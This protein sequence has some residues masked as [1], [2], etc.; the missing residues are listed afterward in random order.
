M[1][2]YLIQLSYAP[3]VLAAGIKKPT[4]RT[5][6]IAKLVESVG[7][8]LVGSWLAFGEYDAVIV[9]DGGDNVSAAALAIVVTASGAFKAF[10]TTPLLTVAEGMEAM[11][12][13]GTISYSPPSRV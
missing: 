1:P 8:K 4:D 10:K 2:S 6:I 12:K 13:A 9:I 7:A 5:E 11:K 3:E